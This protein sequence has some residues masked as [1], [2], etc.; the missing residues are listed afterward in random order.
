MSFDHNIPRNSIHVNPNAIDI[1]RPSSRQENDLPPV[2]SPALV[3][4]NTGAEN[5]HNAANNNSSLLARVTSVDSSEALSTLSASNRKR[6]RD[7]NQ[8][9]RDTFK[10]Q[11]NQAPVQHVCMGLTAAHIVSLINDTAPIDSGLLTSLPKEERIKLVIEALTAKDDFGETSLH[12]A[13]WT[14]KAAKIANHI[15]LLEML[16]DEELIK[17][18][19]KLLSPEGNKGIIFHLLLWKGTA[20][21]CALYANLLN[22]LSEE[23][24]REVLSEQLAAKDNEGRTALHLAFENRNTAGIVAYRDLLQF[25]PKE[26]RVDLLYGQLAAKDS[27][28]RMALHLAFESEDVDVVAAYR[29]LM[30]LLPGAKM[31]ALLMAMG[32][33]NRT[34]LHMSI[35]TDNRSPFALERS[36]APEL[37]ELLIE[38]VELSRVKAPHV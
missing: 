21:V 4:G 32:P 8:V 12:S 17:L 27:E 18:I 22:L 29:D 6:P 3:P 28:G 24:H 20:E 2:L 26:R 15:V 23:K 9:D 33:D 30:K 19:P 35:K 5:M 1:S 34:A 13:F 7:D 10:R 37:F 14:N 36:L 16:P 38:M 31:S 11:L 25:L